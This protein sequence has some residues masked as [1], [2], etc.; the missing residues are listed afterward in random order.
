MSKFNLINRISKKRISILYLFVLI[1]V[2]VSCSTQVW[3]TYVYEKRG[4]YICYNVSGYWSRWQQN[5]FTYYGIFRSNGDMHTD[6]VSD[7]IFY[8]KGEIPSK[9]YFI[10]I[11]I[12]NYRQDIDT[13][14]GYVEYYVS[15]EYPTVN[16]LFEHIYKVGSNGLYYFPKVNGNAQYPHTVKRKANAKIEIV[17]RYKTGPNRNEPSVIYCWFDNVGFNLD[18]S[19]VTWNP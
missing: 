11:H 1:P 5:S 8:P 10:R 2:L 13:F 14:I 19:V 12:D 6:G 3:Q 16:K 17:E 9:N 7:Y 18:L 15:D 4:F